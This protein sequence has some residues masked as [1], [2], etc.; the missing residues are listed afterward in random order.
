M[1]TYFFALS[2]WLVSCLLSAI[3]GIRDLLWTSA[4]TATTSHQLYRICGSLT[5]ER[6]HYI[7]HLISWLVHR[8]NTHLSHSSFGRLI[9]WYGREIAGFRPS[10]IFSHTVGNLAIEPRG[11]LSVLSD[12]FFPCFSP[13]GNIVSHSRTSTCFHGCWMSP[14]LFVGHL[15]LSFSPI[16]SFLPVV[17]SVR[18]IDDALD[19]WGYSW[20]L[21]TLAFSLFLE[22]RIRTV[23]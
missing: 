15:T 16:F 23:V 7:A 6:S 13:L 8:S 3:F 18:L 12:F 4:E 10:G 11:A 14:I 19:R 9:S 1:A 20:D 22:I 5:W 21:S 17:D 2:V